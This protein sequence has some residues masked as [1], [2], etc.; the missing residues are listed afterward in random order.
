[1]SRLS[2]DEQ[3]GNQA[4][5]QIIGVNLQRAPRDASEQSA[6]ALTRENARIDN[7]AR[8]AGQE[9]KYLGGIREAETRVGEFAERVAGNM[10]KNNHVQSEAAEEIDAQVARGFAKLGRGSDHR[11]D[12]LALKHYPSPV[13]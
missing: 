3:D 6:D 12:Q 1:M 5:D 7:S 2:D 8:D 10:V 4:R 13:Q 9:D 11:G